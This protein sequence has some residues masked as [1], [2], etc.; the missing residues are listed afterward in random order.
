MKKHRWKPVSGYVD[1]HCILKCADCLTHDFI[2]EVIGSE[3]RSQRRKFI[4]SRSDC[5]IL[6]VELAIVRI[7]GGS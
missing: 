4:F 6:L 1:S 7:L 2:T 3:E 5:D